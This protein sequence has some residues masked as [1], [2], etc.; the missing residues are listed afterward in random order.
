MSD[1]A[2][3]VDVELAVRRYLGRLARRYTPL[4]V[5]GVTL[6]LILVLVRPATTSK[7]NAVSS[8]ASSSGTPGDAASG[9]T[10]ESV[11]GGG[12]STAAG[13]TT[14]RGAAGPV[15][16]ARGVTSAAAAGSPGVTRS[17]VQ[18]GP[19]VRQVTWSVYAPTCIPLYKGN[20]GGGSSFGVS[21]DT[22]VASFR[23]TGSAEEKAAYAAVGA[24]APGSD[25]QYLADLRTYVDFFNKTFEL[26]GRRVVV[27]DFTGQSDNLEESQGRSLAGAQADA[28]KARQIGAFVDITQSPTLAS[29]QPYEEGLAHERVVSIGAVG[30]PQSWHEQ[31]APYGYSFPITPDGTTA[32]E[33]IVNGVCA[34]MAGMPAIYAGDPLYQRQNRV[35]GLVT[36]ENPVYL[37]L[38]NVVER[39]LKQRCGVTLARRINYSINV[40]TM[41]NQSVSMVAQLKAANVTTPICICDPI[42][43]ITISQAANSQ[44]YKPEWLAVAWGDPQGRQVDQE[45]MHHTLAYSGSYP[46][47]KQTEAYR[48]FKLANPAGEPQEQYYPVAY[49][50]AMY[51]FDVLQQA[52]PSLTPATFR[53]GAFSMPTSPAG[54]AGVWGGGRGRYSPLLAAQIGRWEP[55]ANSGFDDRKG[56]WQ[57]CDGGK[58]YPYLDP[59]GWGAAHTQFQC[60]P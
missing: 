42:V 4:L 43:E 27:K 60:P 41:A 17:G 57:S 51:L 7:N 44:Q 36:P 54:D 5:V 33:G 23:R 6:A 49:Y 45:Q 48:T 35:W 52:G 55:N 19:G 25:D 16:V 11:A 18:C 28:A 37:E 53:E 46:V 24:A 39:G 34:H 3:D 10:A 22:I 8:G 38:G 9:A 1:R 47:K 14:P 59:A 31:Y 58:W 12:S 30:L 21:G 13:G 56:G 32:A 20:N 50:M 29:T 40:A 15:A 26:Y 2:T